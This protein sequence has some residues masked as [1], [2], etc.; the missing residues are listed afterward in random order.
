MRPLVCQLQEHDAAC[1]HHW[2]M[3]CPRT[4]L[5]Q[6]PSQDTEPASSRLVVLLGTVGVGAGAGSGAGVAVAVADP[7][8][9]EEAAS[10][11]PT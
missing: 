1:R 4:G 5:K 6:E 9:L 7:H 11:E 10:L 2:E 8:D 3:Q